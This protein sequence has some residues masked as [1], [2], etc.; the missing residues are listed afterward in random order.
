MA[1]CACG[2]PL[3]YKDPAQRKKVEALVKELGEN[4]PVNVGSRTWLVP[5]HFIA[6]HGLKSDEL[7][8]LPY[9]YGFKEVK[10]E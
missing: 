9:K 7:E 1:K 6:L 2:K 3:H 5:R 10:H 8:W 4:I